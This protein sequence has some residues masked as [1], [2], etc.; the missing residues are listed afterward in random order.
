MALVAQPAS[1][2][3]TVNARAVNSQHNSSRATGFIDLLT[4]KVTKG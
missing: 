3:P 2:M 4:H 1:E